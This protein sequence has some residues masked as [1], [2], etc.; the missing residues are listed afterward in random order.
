ML[1]ESQ[2]KRLQKLANI[3]TEEKVGDRFHLYHA[4]ITKPD[5]SILKSFRAGITAKK[6]VGMA[7][8]QGSGFYV[9][10][11]K[12][13]ALSRTKDS[14]FVSAQG[15]GVENADAEYV[16][17]NK[18]RDGYPLIVTLEVDSMDPSKFDVD[19]EISGKIIAE[20]IIKNIEVIKNKE[21]NCGNVTYKLG[22]SRFRNDKLLVWD[23]KQ[24]SEEG[25]QPHPGNALFNFSP[26]QQFTGADADNIGSLLRCMQDS[27]QEFFHNMEKEMFEGAEAIKYIGNEI[28][29]PFKL[30]IIDQN[31]NLIDVTTNDPK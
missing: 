28:L 7:A 16:S 11:K 6:S 13:D 17:F 19:S 25:K 5:M 18:D 21:F 9:F 2:K 26:T 27:D 8:S 12:D 20:L 14:K 3:K 22:T 23:I 4:S 30:E 24:L 29:K 1:T 15:S 31:G 10:T